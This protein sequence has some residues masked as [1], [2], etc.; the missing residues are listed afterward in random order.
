MKGPSQ[1]PISHNDFSR[2]HCPCNWLIPGALI[3][4]LYMWRL[5]LASVPLGR[6][7][8]SNVAL[9]LIGLDFTQNNSA[10][11]PHR[12]AQA[13][14]ARRSGIRRRRRT[15]HG[16]PCGGHRAGA[17]CPP[18]F[19]S[20]ALPL[21]PGPKRNCV[22]SGIARGAGAGAS[23]SAGAGRGLAAGPSALILIDLRIRSTVHLDHITQPRIVVWNGKCRSLM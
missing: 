3:A 15:P 16:H 6:L 22:S 2:K 8:G 21:T 18:I 14:R 17:R 20:P 13:L 10:R 19:A 4:P 9:S 5:R 7:R 11:I 12:S 23:Y 1:G